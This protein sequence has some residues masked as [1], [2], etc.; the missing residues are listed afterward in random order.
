MQTIVGICGPIGCGKS[1][2]AEHLISS[3]RFER[4]RFA[5]PLKAMLA[6]LGLTEAE[7]DGNLK[8]EPC[9]RFGGAT[10]RH[11]MQTIGTEWGRNCVHPNLWVLA[12]QHLLPKNRDVVVDD[13]RFQNEAKII[14][15]LGG[16]LI[17]IDRPGTGPLAAHA[18]EQQ[19]I[20]GD[21]IIQNDRGL[22]D[23]YTDLDWALSTFWT[24]GREVA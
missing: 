10:P 8:E 5:G 21:I 18:S 9:E 24:C 11:M 16:I 22:D 14:R 23:L 1:A 3:Y 17:Q 19:G 12:W 6:T 7:I 13:V 15:D 2:A 4:R 20:K